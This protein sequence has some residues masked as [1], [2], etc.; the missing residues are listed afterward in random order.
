MNNDHY[1][2]DKPLSDG[3]VLLRGKGGEACTN[4]KHHIER[5]SP[6]GFEW[7]YAGSGPL[8][9]SLNIVE[10]ILHDMNYRGARVQFDTGS[11]FLLTSNLYKQFCEK[12]I[13]PANKAGDFIDYQDLYIWVD[14]HMSLTTA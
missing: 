9:L 2:P 14:Y 7:G 3:L 13:E 12:F 8:E 1:L 6:D 11:C 10:E 4:V 5:H